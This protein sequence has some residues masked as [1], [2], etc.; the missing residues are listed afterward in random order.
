MRCGRWARH[1]KDLGASPE[2][3]SAAQAGGETQ[4]RMKKHKRN[5]TNDKLTNED[6]S[7]YWFIHLELDVVSV[8]EQFV[9]PRRC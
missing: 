3:H 4:S 6:I 1:W 8:A 5:I 7:T 2:L 9:G